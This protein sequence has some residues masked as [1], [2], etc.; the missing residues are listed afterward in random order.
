MKKRILLLFLAPL[1]LVGCFEVNEEITINGNGSGAVIFETSIDDGVVK[2]LSLGQDSGTFFDRN[3]LDERLKTSENV[4]R[5]EIREKVEGKARKTTVDVTVKD[6]TE[7]MKDFTDL[8]SDSVKDKLDVGDGSGEKPLFRV[9]KLENGNLKFT[10]D[11]AGGKKAESNPLLSGMFSGKY[12]RVKVNGNIVSANGSI[13][14][15]KN[16]VS[17]EIPIAQLMNGSSTLK[18][19]EAEIEGARP[20]GPVAVLT[21]VV[22]VFAMILIGLM[23]LRRKLLS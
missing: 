12:F 20:G 23:F 10:Q 16:S 6:M 3:A 7:T 14:E 15:D 13:A 19:L 18:L 5:F 1:F 9:T 22:I 17:W 21:V 4:E 2:L 8:A 11:M